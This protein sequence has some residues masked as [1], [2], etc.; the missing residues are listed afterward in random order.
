MSWQGECVIS[1]P[2]VSH[3][4]LAEFDIDA[5]SVV[6]VQYPS[7]IGLKESLLAELM[8]PEGAHLRDSDWTVFRAPSDTSQ[9][10]QSSTAKSTSN[11]DLWCINLVCTRLDKSV[12]RGA[13][14]LRSICCCCLV[15]LNSYSAYLTTIYLRL[16]PYVFVL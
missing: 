16:I 14:R 7:P 5:G 8:L 4:A 15:L 2:L 1:H 9:L 3:I 6:R 13:G 12:R 10:S 11:R